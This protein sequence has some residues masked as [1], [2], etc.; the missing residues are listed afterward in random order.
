MAETYYLAA[1]K[2][3]GPLGPSILDIQCLFLAFVYEKCRLRPLRAC[4]YIQQASTRLQAHHLRRGVGG[5]T[6]E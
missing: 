6:L 5:R 1:S 3:V 4:F 2:R